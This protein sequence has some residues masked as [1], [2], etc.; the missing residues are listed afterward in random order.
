VSLRY[1]AIE[2][3]P[4]RTPEAFL[5]LHCALIRDIGMMFGEMFDLEALAADRAADGQWD[6]FFSGPPLRVA[7]RVGSPASPVAVK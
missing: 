2:I 4:S 6:C 7:G 1:V 3:Q 5:P